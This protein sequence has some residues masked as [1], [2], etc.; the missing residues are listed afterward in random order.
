MQIEIY[1]D[2]KQSDFCQ[3]VALMAAYL[4]RH[5]DGADR[6]KEY[7]TGPGLW[8]TQDVIEYTGWKRTYVQRLVS[9][10]TLPYIPGKPHKYIPAS[11][12]QTLEAMQVG[13]KYGRRKSTL[14]TKTTNTN[15]TKGRK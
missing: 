12:K 1:E 4:D 3:L 7:M 15:T 2:P 9:N 5:P 6:L 8:D 10:G 14:K 13:G 11:V